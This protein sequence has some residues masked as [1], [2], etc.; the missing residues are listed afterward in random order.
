MMMSS[1]FWFSLLPLLT[2]VDGQVATCGVGDATPL[3]IVLD[4]CEDL[5]NSFK[6]DVRQL[7]VVEPITNSE[8]N[9]HTT[10]FENDEVCLDPSGCYF[11]RLDA[12]YGNGL[13]DGG[14][15]SVFYDGTLIFSGGAFW[16]P[17]IADPT[18]PNVDSI[19]F[20][21]G[22]LLWNTNVVNG[23]REAT[24]S[25]NSSTEPTDLPTEGPS[26]QPTPLPSGDQ[27]AFMP[28]SISKNSVLTCSCTGGT[29]TSYQP[30]FYALNLLTHYV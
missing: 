30:K 3:R 24:P 10:V 23:R 17:S 11:V 7:G 29:N 12:D 8:F 28:P 6:W 14:T 4:E 5:N 27:S 26:V 15:Y 9:E 20:G 2:F 13:P 18:R 16:S 1:M 22:C 21:D 25:K 19:N